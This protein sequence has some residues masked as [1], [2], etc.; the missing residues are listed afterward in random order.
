MAPTYPLVLSV[1]YAEGPEGI[2]VRV[3]HG[4]VVNGSLKLVGALLLLLI[5]TSC[6]LA[7]VLTHLGFLPAF[8][9]T[10]NLAF[11]VLALVLLGP[12]IR[13]WL[14]GTIGPMTKLAS[15]PIVTL[16]QRAGPVQAILDAATGVAV[17]ATDIVGT[18]T[19][20]NAG[21]ER[22]LGYS[23]AEIVGKQTPEILH[24]AREIETQARALS[25]EFG[26]SIGG[27]SALVERVRRKGSEEREWTF[28]RKDG[29]HLPVNLMVT[30]QKDSAGEIVGYLGIALDMTERRR[31]TE[32]LWR[33]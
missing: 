14:R 13:K 28:V 22:M 21:S 33:A 32:A 27:F 31:A 10:V 25:A 20:F 26:T 8:F 4:G 19:L 17:I 2:G 16:D 12:L 9:L 29:T 18:I 15:T 7:V 5:L 11:L 23:A 6:G 24:D 1:E 30:C 3:A